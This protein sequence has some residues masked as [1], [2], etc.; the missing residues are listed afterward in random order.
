MPSSYLLDSFYRLLVCAHLQGF[1]ASGSIPR[2]LATHYVYQAVLRQSIKCGGSPVA[3]VQ[4]PTC[5]TVRTRG[6]LVLS[7]R[8]GL[9]HHG[10]AG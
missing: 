3:P 6:Q 8:T 4:Y 9:V 10:L 7:L 5:S 2:P 1:E